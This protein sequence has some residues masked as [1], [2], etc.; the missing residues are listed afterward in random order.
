M[1]EIR[2]KVSSNLMGGLGN[3]LFQI[4]AAYSYGKKFSKE[5][6]F[7]SASS[8]G[9]HSR[10]ETYENNVLSVVNL[11]STIDSFTSLTEPG[12]NYFEIPDV[13]G[14]VLLNG[15]FQSEK[16]FSDISDEIRKMYTS[17]EVDILPE[18][19]EKIQ[20]GTT[21]AI[22]VR[23]GDF[24]KYP[25]HHPVQDMSY[26][27]NA[28]NH[29]PEGTTFLV[30]SDDMNWC[31]DNFKRL[32]NDFFFVEGNL[33]FEDLSIM[34]SCTHNIISNSTFSWWAAWLNSN[35][36]K[37]VIA[38]RNW[39]GAAYTQLDTRDLYCESWTVI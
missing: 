19:N 20:G 21:C 12:F 15:Y 23:R 16:Y 8:S 34:R 22:H 35:P 32:E 39:F 13:P 37:I 3:Y 17:Y 33:D 1:N 2:N 7:N 24:L 30:F 29:M 4:A 38:P 14:N 36:D 28:I 10:I 31:K 18:I 25:D 9:P 6:V 26:F 27:I 5:P 11:R